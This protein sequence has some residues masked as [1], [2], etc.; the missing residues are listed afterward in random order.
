MGLEVVMATL[1][2]G[3]FK[4]PRN[5]KARRGFVAVLWQPL[6]E[7]LVVRGGAWESSISAMWFSLCSTWNWKGL[8]KKIRIARRKSNVGVWD[9]LLLFASKT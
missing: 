4:W 7:T 1:T 5:G 6:V 9:H 3:Q 8:E 2:E